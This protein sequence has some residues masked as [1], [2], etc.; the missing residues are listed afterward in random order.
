[1]ARD[2]RKTS[3]SLERLFNP[4][5]IAV[6][7]ASADPTKLGSSPLTA[8]TLMG[9]DGDIHIVHPRYNELMGH[10]CVPDIASLP[11]GLDA[12][13]ILLPAA[14]A[15]EAAEACARK[16]IPGLVVIAQ[17]FGEAGPEGRERD[18]RLLGLARAHGLAVCG[19][20]TNGLANVP[21]GLALSIA[22]ALQYAG[23]V[24]PGTVS[25]VSQSGAM[26]ST[27]LTKLAHYG[28]GIAKIATCGNE[29][30]LGVADY[31]DFLVDDDATE[32]IV[33][34][35]ETIRKLD[36]L[37]V[38]LRRARAAGTPVIAIKV[39]E[40][41]G[42]QKAALS[43]TGAI[44]GSYRSTIAFLKAEGVYVAEDM[45]TLAALTDCLM[46]Y[47]WPA[48]V[49]AKP[50]IAAISGGFAAQTADMMARV[51]LTLE[52][53]SPAAAKELTALPTQS[54][55]V[56]PYDIA[57]QNALIPKI[58]EIF[59]RDGFNQLLFGLALLKPEIHEQVVAMILDA[60][61]K[62]FE[63][64]FALAPE[65]DPVER[66]RFNAAGISLYADPAPLL[67]ALRCIEDHRR[68]MVLRL[69]PSAA[70]DVPRVKV[71]ARIGRLNEAESKVLLQSCGFKVPAFQILSTRSRP[72]RLEGLKFPV[73]IK[74]LSDRIA[75]KTELGLVALGL[76]TDAEVAA[77]WVRVAAALA[78]ADPTSDQILV[79]EMVGGGLE[80]ILG[81]HRDSSVGPVVT[82]G[83]G[84][85][86]CEFLDDAV[87]L[88]PPFDADEVKL[89]LS[90]T[91][92]GRLLRGYRG[93][94][95]DTNAL[96][97]A[98]VTLGDLALDQPNI[99]SLE[100]N[101]LRVDGPGAG[102]IPLDAKVVFSAAEAQ[103]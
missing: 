2:T 3:T 74:G 55:P 85:I 71:P 88:V 57:A 36:A 14:Q 82:V 7:G 68:R 64:V 19:P 59:K 5:T 12:A 63:Q 22:P 44:A 78:E 90:D 28:V 53:P 97:E 39:G 27:L 70:R 75:H 40:S 102:V 10:R 6:I 60:K 34:Y 93:Q 41:E 37:R 13:M 89:A 87:V 56:N 58:I 26:V 23:R 52:D 8:M 65:I 21:R 101:P 42:G 4:R 69:R 51:G 46:R 92:F 50:F 95:F 45:E 11:D 94:S 54:H 99:Q 16:N 1:M 62:G 31:V 66:E 15:L 76:R 48:D 9:F 91:R 77:A 25:V 84:G 83:A 49:A 33:L 86:L 73:V 47:E 30:V 35:L 100:I 67:K 81:L 79:E 80:A 18:V 17:G 38:A 98:A 103:S 61:M 72:D 43:H 32:V 24:K 29:L 96:A 20:N